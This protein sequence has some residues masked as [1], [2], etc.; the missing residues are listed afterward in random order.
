MSKE[1]IEA[2]DNKKIIK[3][4]PTVLTENQIWDKVNQMERMR[5][6]RI[7]KDVKPPD[8]ETTRLGNVIKE[9]LRLAQ[10]DK[11]LLGLIARAKKEKA[12]LIF[13]EDREGEIHGIATKSGA[14]DF[15]DGSEGYDV[16]CRMFEDTFLDLILGE[17]NINYAIAAGYVIFEGANWLLH[18]EVL[19]TLFGKFRDQLTTKKMISHI[20]NI[21][22]KD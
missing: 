5:A 1:V 10:E 16:I 7:Y 11:E 15:Y 13:I 22:K 6:D 14:I 12:I 19:S 21:R 3:T 9:F 2:E 17:I 18:S 20:K 8:I 4:K